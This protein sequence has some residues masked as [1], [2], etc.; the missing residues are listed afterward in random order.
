MKIVTF[1]NYPAKLLGA[2]AVIKM[3][4]DAGFDG[5]DFSFA[6]KRHVDPC[7]YD[8]DFIPFI[9]ELRA[10]ADEI[11]LPCEQ[12]HT[13]FPTLKPG[14]VIYNVHLLPLSCSQR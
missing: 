12:C 6:N 8:D 5:Y 13:I 1:T 9:K 14:G 4:K 7:V 10:Y 11:G 2:K 3:I